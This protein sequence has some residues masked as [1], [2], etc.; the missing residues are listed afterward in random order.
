MCHKLCSQ[1]K[2]ECFKVDLI[3]V[4]N[5]LC[6]GK[7]AIINYSNTLNICIKICVKLFILG[8]CALSII[9]LASDNLALF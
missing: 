1:V 5:F 9:S 6:S 7:C 4:K 3:Y 2:A 8:K